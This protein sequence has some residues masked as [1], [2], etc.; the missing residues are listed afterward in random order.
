MRTSLEYYGDVQKVDNLHNFLKN[1]NSMYDSLSLHS[2]SHPPG[3]ILLLWGVSKVFGQGVLKAALGVIIMGA[4]SILPIYL[5]AKDLY[6]KEA[7]VIALSLYILSPDIILFTATCMNIIFALFSNLS[8][9]F[10]FKSFSKDR[11]LYSLLFGLSYALN[12]FMGFDTVILAIFFMLVSLYYLKTRNENTKIFSSLVSAALS[13][14]VFYLIIY[15]LTDY[16]I[17]GTLK[18]VSQHTS[19][20]YM[21]ESGNYNQ[22]Y[23]FWRFGNIIAFSLFVGVPTAS[24]YL[25]ELYQLTKNIF[26]RMNTDI[27]MLAFIVTFLFIDLALM[28][29]MGE[30]ERLWLFLIPFLVI[31]AAK[32]LWNHCQSTK[33]SVL[34]HLTLTLLFMQSLLL[35]LVLYT[36]W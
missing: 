34:L 17:F 36:Y 22:S 29:F 31:P 11:I 15:L 12:L 10:F 33:S 7:A 3:P 24:L 8:V 9:Y 28:F 21:E 30:V 6:G 13:F 35:E 19:R 23:I 14:A 25:K 32:N 2:R 16:S 20:F 4:L 1:Y 18:N 26:Q 5:L 27:Y